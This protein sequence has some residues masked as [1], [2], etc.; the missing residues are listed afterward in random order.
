MKYLIASLTLAVIASPALAAGDPAAGEADFRKCKACHSIIAP[1]GT[2]IQKGG[3]IGP[4]L[5]GVIGRQIGTFPGFTYS[6]FTKA[7]G[8]DGTVWDEAKIAAYLPDPS[9]WLQQ[10]TGDTS[11]KSKMAFKMKDGA[12]DVAAYLA[13]IK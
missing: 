2:A 3:S 1:D 8:A 5:Y 6:D 7:A 13:S 9:G 4:N 10:K 11:A 12:E